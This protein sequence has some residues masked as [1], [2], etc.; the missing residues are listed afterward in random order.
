MQ[1]N[2]ERCEFTLKVM[3]D[4]YA[5][6]NGQLLYPAANFFRLVVFII[7]EASGKRVDRQ[8]VAHMLWSNGDH[9]QTNADFRQTIARIKRFQAR[10]NFQ[11]IAFDANDL[12]LEH[13]DQ[14][15]VDLLELLKH[16]AASDAANWVRACEIYTGDLLEGCGQAGRVYEEWLTHHRSVLREKFLTTI[17]QALLPTSP[18]ARA[19][20]LLC[21]GRMLNVD[22]F[23]EGA[24]RAMM[25]EAAAHA[26]LALLRHVFKQCEELLTRELGVRPSIETLKYFEHLV[27][28]CLNGQ[29]AQSDRFDC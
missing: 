2:G 12:W 18:L 20:R 1:G 16:L 9:V 8:Q 28:S 17:S 21:A 23:H 7:I 27:Q 22:P 13:T 11:L 29:F 4:C 10:H 19:E 14:I 24:Y 25:Y 5:T 3:G 26:D 15:S 6:I